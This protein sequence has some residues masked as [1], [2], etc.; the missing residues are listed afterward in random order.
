MQFVD[1]PADAPI[2]S[3]VTPDGFDSAPEAEVNPGKKNNAWTSCVPLLRTNENRVATFNGAVLLAVGK[4][5]TA[6]TVAN[7]P[8]S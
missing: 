6:P 8:I 2:G 4:P 7:G 1:P 3:R 5:C